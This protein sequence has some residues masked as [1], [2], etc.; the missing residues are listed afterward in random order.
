MVGYAHASAPAALAGEWFVPLARWRVLASKR[1]RR[2]RDSLRVLFAGVLELFLARSGVIN[3][4]SAGK[5]HCG[6]GG[7]G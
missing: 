2:R 1:W 6:V 5:N 4:S 3:S 7:D